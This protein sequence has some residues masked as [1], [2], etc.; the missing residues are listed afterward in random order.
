M[1]GFAPFPLGPLP[2][3]TLDPL[4]PLRTDDGHDVGQIPGTFPS[5]LLDPDQAHALGK[6]QGALSKATTDAG[7]GCDGING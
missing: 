1:Q 2:W 6:A 5:A 4:P 7:P 3:P